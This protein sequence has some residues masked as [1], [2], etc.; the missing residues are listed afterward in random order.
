MSSSWPEIAEAFSGIDPIPFHQTWQDV[1]DAQPAWVKIAAGKASLLFYAEF[2]DYDISN[3][4]GKF[5]DPAR[6]K[7]DFLEIILKPEGQSSYY[8]LHVTPQ[9]LTSQFRFS[10]AD[11][12]KLLDKYP[13]MS[14][15]E[16]LCVYNDIFKSKT[17]LTPEQNK[18]N[19][20]TEVSLPAIAEGRDLS[21]I[22]KIQ[23][24]VCRC[25]YTKSTETYSYSST[26]P[27]SK[28]FFHNQDEWGTL[29]L[30]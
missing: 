13:D 25:D 28:Y 17:N 21:L 22:G 7:G 2:T 24:A 11:A 3:P 10:D 14:A 19:I 30:R 15:T 16:I 29:I 6:N 23:F 27:F 20:F 4:A 26:A 1:K 12:V 5:N 9:N 8:E 18:W